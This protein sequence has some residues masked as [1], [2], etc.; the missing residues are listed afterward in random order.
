MTVSAGHAPTADLFKDAFRAHP[1]GIAVLTAQ[2]PDGPVGLT[3]SS[4]SSVS[5][6]PPVLTFSVSTASSSA[7]ALVRADTLLVH[8]LGA[9][10]L[11]IARLFATRGADRFGGAVAWQSLPSGE[12]LLTDAPWALRCRILHRLP[13][14]GSMILAAEVVSIEQRG[15]DDAAPLVYHNR[16]YHR[17]DDRSMMG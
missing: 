17:L 9:D 4:V 14:G 11:R 15:H 6:E 1:A 7:A 13:V 10:Q 2:G 16:S 5:A 8:L 12:P 3:A